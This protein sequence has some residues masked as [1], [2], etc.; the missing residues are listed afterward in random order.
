MIV[1]VFLAALAD[2]ACAILIAVGAG[3]VGFGLALIRALR[4]DALTNLRTLC[5]AHHDDKG[6]V[7][8]A[9]KARLSEETNSE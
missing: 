3:L 7:R 1:W 2:I 8:R 9:Y 5:L 4:Y 6:N